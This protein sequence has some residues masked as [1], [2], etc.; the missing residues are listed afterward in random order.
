M[1]CNATTLR[2]S[3]GSSINMH[4]LPNGELIVE[5]KSFIKALEEM[6][7]SVADWPNVYDKNIIRMHL[8]IEHQQCN[9]IRLMWAG[10]FQRHPT[11]RVAM[12]IHMDTLNEII[13]T[14]QRKN[15][16][17]QSSEQWPLEQ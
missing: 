13:R 17:R 4:T 12:H 1:V 16:G 14:A 6:A 5:Y 8:N 7:R 10:F 9:Q 11:M 2:A 3:R 15:D